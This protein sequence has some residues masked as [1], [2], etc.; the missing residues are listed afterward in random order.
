MGLMSEEIEEETVFVE[1]VT[2]TGTF[3]AEWTP[4]L[5]GD[6][7]QMVGQGRGLITVRA[8][9]THVAIIPAQNVNHIRLKESE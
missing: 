6:V 2:A 1:I 9:A 8:D 3:T 5:L 7:M 4:E